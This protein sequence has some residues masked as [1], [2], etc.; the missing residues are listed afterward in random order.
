[1]DQ[2][3]QRKTMIFQTSVIKRKKEIK[4]ENEERKKIN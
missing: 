4:N 3:M 2:R 1:M